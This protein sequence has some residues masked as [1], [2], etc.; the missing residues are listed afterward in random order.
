MRTCRAGMLRRAP[1]ARRG[2]GPGRAAIF[3]GMPGRREPARRGLRGCPATASPV[4]QP[5]C[6]EGDRAERTRSTGLRHSHSS[7][8]SEVSGAAAPV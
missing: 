5:G 3:T 6:E 2:R 7:N 1:A 8:L 4:S